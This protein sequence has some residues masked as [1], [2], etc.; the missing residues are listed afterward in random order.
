MKSPSRCPRGAFPESVHVPP[1]R[2]ALVAVVM[3]VAALCGGNRAHAQQETSSSR[4]FIPSSSEQSTPF[5]GVPLPSVIHTSSPADTVPLCL[6]ADLDEQ[7]RDRSISA[8]K[9][10]GDLNVG[11][12]RTVRMIYFLPNDRPFRADVVQKMK[13]DISRVQTFYAGQMRAHGYGDRTFR[14]ETD[15]Q[16]EPLVHHM[17]GQHPDSHYLD[18]TFR[19]TVEVRQAFDVYANVYL[20]VV[21]NST[22]QIGLNGRFGAGAGVKRGK[23]GGYALVTGN[24]NLEILTHEFGHAFGLE[25]DF[26]DSTYMMSYGKLRYRLS[27]CSA[28]LLAVHPYFSPNIS[29]IE[30]RE[31]DIQL[32]SSSTYPGDLTSV[33]VRFEVSDPGGLHQAVLL[34]RT[35]QPH[36]AAGMREVHTCRAL[37]GVQDTV[38]EFDYDGVP[39]VQGVDL[40]HPPLHSIW[41]SV[42]DKDGNRGAL[43]VGLLGISPNLVAT[44]AKW[45]D[46]W[47]VESVAFPRT[48]TVLASGARGGTIALWDIAEREWIVTLYETYDVFSVAFSPDGKMI[49]SASSGINLWDVDEQE[50]ITATPLKHGNTASVVFFSPDGTMLA[51]GSHSDSVIKLWSVAKQAHIGTLEG[52]T[53]PV[54]TLSFSP[55]GTTLASATGD[56]TIRLWDIA[57]EQNIAILEGHTDGVSSVTFSPDGSTLASGGLDNTIRIW[58]VATQ[59]NIATLNGHTSYVHGVSFSPDGTTL[60]SGSEDHTIRLWDV[61]TGKNIATFTG[62]KDA[63]HSVSFSPDGALLA[64]GAWDN[65]VRLWD[66][67]EWA[68]VVPDAPVNFQAAPGSEQV[69]L[70]W[71]APVDDR[72]SEI[73]GYAYRHLEY[74]GAFSQWTD[75]S[76]SGPGGANEGG[77]TVTGLKSETMY[78][79]ELRAVNKHGG[80]RSASANVTLPPSPTSTESEELPAEVALMGNYPN[81]FNPE[82]TIGYALPHAGKVRLVVY[83]LLGHEVAVLVD[84]PQPAGRHTVR[85]HGDHLPSGPYAYRLQAG[86]E[87]VVRT[88]ILVK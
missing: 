3:A 35:V 28:R 57:T 75:I 31:P 76:D 2:H 9:Q 20:I 85:F 29:T 68:S 15:A 25:H 63:I 27:E 30:G 84:G 11:E 88:M 19:S 37:G 38:V 64:S 87:V 79:F 62:H 49:A 12:P 24:F 56:K 23:N 43:Y 50:R 54:S 5:S 45:R 61:A 47:N 18:N 26:H 66:V 74:G 6:P 17:D 16:G 55:D 14:F 36:P 70:S 69:S 82:T 60:A 32:V 13:D 73:T 34:A 67:F 21:D 53:M 1:V 39:S 58:D 65:T 52:H 8:A 48:G 71:E 42:V 41:A 83:D 80:G 7:E 72:G 10:Q 86:D 40:S 77:Y 81:P 46:T 33:P 78:T 4:S 59:S 22:N 44:L 51:S